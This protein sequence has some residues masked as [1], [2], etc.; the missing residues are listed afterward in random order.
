MHAVFKTAY[1][2]AELTLSGMYK[3]EMFYGKNVSLL[4]NNNPEDRLFF[5]RHYLDLRTFIEWGRKVF[6]VPV[7]ECMFTVRN[8]A[9]WG[10]PA[11]I[12]STTNTRVRTL[13]DVGGV[14]RHGFPRNIFWIREVWLNWN[15][16]KT[17]GL[18]IANKHTFML[19][20]FAFELGRGIALGDAY[21]VGPEL[22]GFYSDATVDQY[23]YGAKLTGEII[24]KVLVYDLY[25]AI[26]QCKTSSLGDT[27]ERIRGQEFG[28]LHTPQR[29]F[30]SIN[31]LIAARLRWDVFN[32]ERFGKLTIEP[33]GLMNHDPEQRVQFDADASSKLGTLGM[34]GE[35]YGNWFEGGFDWAINLGQQ[36]VKG[37]DRNEIRLEN[38]NGEIVEINSHVVDKTTGK[39]VPFFGSTSPAQKIIFSST[40]EQSQNGQVIGTTPGFIVGGIPGNG[41]TVIGIVNGS[42]V[43]A[44]APDI[45]LQNAKDRFRDPYT[46]LY[47]GW[48]FVGDAAVWAY[49]K[50]L[51]VAFGAGIA[52]GDNDPHEVAKDGNFNGFVGLQE[53]YSGKRV[54]SAFLLG[55]AGK[56]KRPIAAPTDEE[57]PNEF[58]QVVSGFTNLVFCGSALTWT[59]TRWTKRIKVNPNFLLYWQERPTLKYDA[60]AQTFLDTPARS[61][62][63]AELN[64]FAEFFPVDAL[65]AYFVGSVFIPG[66][67]YKDVQGMPLNSEQR[68]ALNRLDDTGVQDPGTLP[69]LGVNAA[70]TINIGLEYRF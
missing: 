8:K 62:L 36:R 35:Y 15:L 51:L 4:N 61:F 21:A 16:T 3:P 9:I 25:G 19:G 39:K 52:S 70:Y 12:A 20:A 41:Q 60:F 45:I 43:G 1:G 17:L 65:K 67:H 63:G 34:A 57:A 47:K 42:D 37:W 23:A 55:G 26:L 24:N 22:L 14:H 53:I 44:V 68:R 29:G 33:Y 56:L 38:R 31:F 64:V 13:D 50:E 54:K 48:M 66:G 5:A 58:A 30:G 27:A 49:K 59:P 40:Q 18:K 2:D 69:N 28:R 7:L 10:N 11:S 32:N 6:E 46:N